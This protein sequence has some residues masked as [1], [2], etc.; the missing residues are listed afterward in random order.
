MDYYKVLKLSKSKLV[1]V[2]F[3]M[4]FPKIP[5]KQKKAI[6]LA[7]KRGYYS[8]PKKIELRDLAKESGVSTPTFQENLRK[9]EI[10]LLPFILEQNI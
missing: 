6:E 2:Y 8:Y 5:E 4:L 3:P 9:A 10:K 7:H 1:D